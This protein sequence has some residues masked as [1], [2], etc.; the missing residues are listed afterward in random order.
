MHIFDLI[1]ISAALGVGCGEPDDGA[2]SGT[3]ADGGGDA[4]TGDGGGVGDGGDTGDDG[5]SFTEVATGSVSPDMR[6]GLKDG[7]GPMMCDE[8]S[9]V[10]VSTSSASE[11][12]ETFTETFGKDVPDVDLTGRVALIS[13][14]PMCPSVHDWLAMD[15]IDLDGSTLRVDETYVSSGGGQEVACIYNVVT[16]SAVDFDSIEATLGSGFPT[17]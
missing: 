16:I 8:A 14:L 9:L 5:I 7:N 10:V 4:G 15:H 12:T 3:A 2:D 17:E 6:C 11:F 1:M 13:Y